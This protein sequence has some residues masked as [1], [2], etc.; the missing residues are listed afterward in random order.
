[1]P[2]ADVEEKDEVTVVVVKVDVEEKV[3]AVI[4]GR[5]EGL[6]EEN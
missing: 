1:M 6:K 3:E 4:T 5:L 2:I